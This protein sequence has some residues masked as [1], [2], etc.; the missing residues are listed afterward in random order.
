MSL[1]FVDGSWDCGGLRWL[2]DVFGNGLDFHGIGLL[3][4]LCVSILVRKPMQEMF[5]GPNHGLSS[6]AEMGI[7][8]R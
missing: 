7:L 6:V 2:C 3:C 4:G 5:G 1:E 8:Q